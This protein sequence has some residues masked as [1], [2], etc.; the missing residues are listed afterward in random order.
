LA[1]AYVIQLL[2]GI[3]TQED[4]VNIKECLIF[5]ILNKIYSGI[6]LIVRP[7]GKDIPIDVILE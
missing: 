2:V 1:T 4:V 6:K 3:I 5:I 7:D